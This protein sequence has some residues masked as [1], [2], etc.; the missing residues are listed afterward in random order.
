MTSW[1][2]DQDPSPFEFPPRRVPSTAEQARLKALITRELEG[3][4]DLL[5]FLGQG[6][7]ATV[8]HAHDRVSGEAVAIKR[9]EPDSRRPRDFYLEMSTMFRLQHPRIV[10]IVNVREVTSGARYLVL[11]FCAG[12]NLRTALTEAR[13][14]GARP[15]P[16]RLK[17]LALQMAE[18]LAVAHRQGLVHRDLKP[19]NILF[20][21]AEPGML[22]G[23]AAIK[24][25]DFGLSR[26]LRHAAHAHGN[27]GRGRPHAGSPAYMAPEQFSERAGRASD[28]YS[29]GVILYELWHGAPPFAGESG[30]MVQQHL[31]QSPRLGEHLPKAWRDLLERMLAKQPEQ[32]PGADELLERLTRLDTATAAVAAQQEPPA[33]SPPEDRC[34]GTPAMALFMQ[35]LGGAAQVV[36][37]AKEGIFRFRAGDGQPR[38]VTLQPD[39]Q[40][41][42]QDESGRVWLIQDRRI[43]RQDS[44]DRFVAIKSLAGTFARMA[45]WSGQ[46]GTAI[47]AAQNAEGIMIKR[48]AFDV[49]QTT[50]SLTSQPSRHLSLLGFLPDGSI[51][52]EHADVTPI[53]RR[54][55]PDGS[56]LGRVILSGACRQYAVGATADDLHLL[57]DTVDGLALGR[58][59]WGQQQWLPEESPKALR[60]LART[61]TGTPDLWAVAADGTCLRCSARGAWQTMDGWP[62]LRDAVHLVGDG[63]DFAA[64][65]DRHGTMWLRFLRDVGN[66]AL[67]GLA[68]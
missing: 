49:T 16:S 7:F 31:K 48:L 3:R 56:L 42:A 8:W 27:E 61:P 11:E 36:A 43:W 55:S 10:R 57:L 19:E 30:E 67:R 18:G 37:V 39:I 1:V 53:L 44:H 63:V 50:W 22:S 15:T 59:V 35:T 17:G 9:F 65:V 60:V 34:L 12:G 38:G 51:L 33:D 4:Y 21:R 58:I 68:S 40:A 28:V 62:D 46:R 32:R 54:F 14:G 29:L 47:I 2:G 6:S 23:S 13:G 66:A 5:G 52:V 25:A 64:T 45:V 41:A 20:D 24:L 26:L